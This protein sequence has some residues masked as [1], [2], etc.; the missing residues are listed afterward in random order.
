MSNKDYK[1]SIITVVYNGAKTIEQTIKSVLGQTYQNIEY[2]VI[3]GG[4]DDGTQ[5]IVESFRA[6]IA[7]FVSE[8]DNGIFDA[9]NKG[10]QQATGDVIGIINSDDWYSDDA[11][12]N[13][14]Q[15]MIQEDVEVIYGKSINVYPDGRERLGIMEPLETIWYKMIVPHPT[16]FVKR[17]IYERLG[18][19]S[20]KYKLGADYE[21][22]L[23]FYSQHVKFGYV[24]QTMAYFRI[25]GRST[26]GLTK[27]LEEHKNIAMEY[28]DLCPYEEKLEKLEKTYEW[29]FF[30]AWIRKGKL[31]SEMLKKYFSTNFLQLGI[32]G[33]GIWGERCFEIIK[34]S[35]IKIDFF[36][37]NNSSKWNQKFHGIK[38]ISPTKL[39]SGKVNILIA[40]EENWLEIKQQLEMLNNETL[41]Y[42][43]LK[44]LA[45]LYYELMQR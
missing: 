35:G 6:S 18:I 37:D 38:V 25:G 20:L 2:I 7:C 41:N 40:V 27:L 5:Q 17:S 11:V 31:L 16:V 28:I 13:A 21:L 19:F 10:I 22:I 14:V 26:Q 12:E 29:L 23:R 34:D 3:D 9:M 33:T 44:E 4:S 32:F 15:C 43:S 24:D 45:A 30:S 8:A 39:G 1:V 42:I 36:V